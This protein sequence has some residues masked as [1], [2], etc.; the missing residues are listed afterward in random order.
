MALSYHCLQCQLYI[1]FKFFIGSCL[2]LVNISDLK[3]L[4]FKHLIFTE[5][6][7]MPLSL[8][9]HVYCSCIFFVLLHTALWSLS[10]Q[11]CCTFCQMLSIVSV[12]VSFHDIY[13]S[14]LFSFPLHSP[15]TISILTWFLSIF[16]YKIK[17][18]FVSLY[19]SS[20]A[21]CHICVSPFGPKLKCVHCLPD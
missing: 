18:L 17:V 9:S 8:C 2:T 1:L 10:F 11:I 14:I 20:T 5:S 16:S 12:D 6:K 13:I 19:I 7:F 15:Y 3:L 21:F 4:K